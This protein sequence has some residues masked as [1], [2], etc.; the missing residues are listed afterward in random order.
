[1]SHVFFLITTVS[2]AA[3]ALVSSFLLPGLSKTVYLTEQTK[4]VPP[5]KDKLSTAQKSLYA[6]SD[7][8]STI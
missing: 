6:I 7:T 3:T 5:P 2:L 4:Y 1:M 8:L